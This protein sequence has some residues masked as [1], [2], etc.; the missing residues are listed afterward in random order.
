[1]TRFPGGVVDLGGGQEPVHDSG[2]VR[3]HVDAVARLG[4]EL[5]GHG[6]G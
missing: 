1:M 2:D 3:E 4:R 5:L 6:L